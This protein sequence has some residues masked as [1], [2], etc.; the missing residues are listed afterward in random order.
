MAAK[1]NKKSKKQRRPR[2]QFTDEFRADVVRLCQSDGES[3]SEI[4]RR[5][6]LTE[7]AVRGWV[8]KAEQES[9]DGGDTPLL[10]TSEKE[11]LQRLRREVKTL[12]M[13][14]EIL[15]KPQRSSRG[16]ANEVRFH[17]RGGREEDV[18]GRAHVPRSGGV[19]LG[20]LR[21]AAS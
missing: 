16:R 10:T 13:E 11:E 18:P 14:R 15:K 20:L 8:K 19:Y 1:K 12:K 6:D 5:L 7:S 2:R 9:L 17:P 4:S 3:I 21:L